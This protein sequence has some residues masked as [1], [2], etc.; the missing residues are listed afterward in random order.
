LSGFA[1]PLMESISG[2]T[3]LN[4]LYDSVKNKTDDPAEFAKLILQE[5]EVEYSLPQDLIAEMK[6]IEGPIVMI[7]NHPIGGI[8]AFILMHILSEVRRDFRL[9]ASPMLSQIEELN[10]A[11]IYVNPFNQSDK[12]GTKSALQLVSYLES[13]GALGIFPNGEATETHIPGQSLEK[14]DWNP[15]IAR[16]IQLTK[17]TVIPVYFHGQSNLLFQLAG[18]LSPNWRKRFQARE[19]LNAEGKNLRFRIGKKISP[20]R[21]AAF[22]Q[23]EQVNTFIQ[24]RIYL[25]SLHFMRKSLINV[26]R[27]KTFVSLP[28]SP[29]IEEPIIEARSPELLQ[30]EITNLPKDQLLCASAPFEVWYLQKKQAPTVMREIGRQREF[31]FRDIGEGSG[32]NCDVDAF[33]EYYYQLV[34]WDCEKSQV[35]GGYRI[36]KIDDI[37]LTKGVNG[38]YLSTLFEISPQLLQ[39]MPGSLELGRSYVSK[40]YQRSYQPLML[41]WTG[42]CHFVAR[43]PKYRYMLGPVSITAEMNNTSKTL[44]VD[45]LQQNEAIP[46]LMPYIKPK[47]AFKGKKKAH[48]YYNTFSTHD[49]RDV[50]DAITELENN[51]M[52]VPMLFKHYLKMGAKMLAFN[53]DPDFSD[54]LDCL[55]VTDLLNTDTHMLSKYMGKESVETYYK[56]HQKSK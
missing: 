10:D 25:L 33:D 42:I 56:F 7:S 5:L 4:E 19:F 28:T 1:R 6:A 27:L 13:G 30:S 16:I 17:A 36:G 40:E 48:L 14:Q 21:L 47:H 18:I 34:L 22:E 20:S 41:L 12:S 54:V 23:P 46:G 51:Q 49:L 53:V 44:L 43:E 37:L 50:Q 8:E 38:I 39:K 35:A 11:L 52:G 2:I 24:S 29:E 45:F 26:D 32:K 9:V 3:Q 31:T 55:M 15:A